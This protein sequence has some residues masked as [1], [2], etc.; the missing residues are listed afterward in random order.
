M[1]R[2][3]L[4]KPNLLGMTVIVVEY[5]K[6]G[7]LKIHIKLKIR[8]VAAFFIALGTKPV[9]PSSEAFARSIEE[10]IQKWEILNFLFLNL[11]QNYWY[12]K[13]DFL[14]L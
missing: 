14:Y 1:P 10:W 13:T 6:R 11:Y 2:Y 4:Q 7:H 12:C 3:S 9:I 8:L 5:K